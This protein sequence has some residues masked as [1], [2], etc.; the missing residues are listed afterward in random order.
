MQ[1]LKIDHKLYV[2]SLMRVKLD[3]LDGIGGAHDTEEPGNE[4]QTGVLP[5]TTT[6]SGESSARFH[7]GAEEKRE[8]SLSE[9]MESLVFSVSDLPRMLESFVNKS[10]VRGE[11]YYRV[12]R[13]HTVTISIP[14]AR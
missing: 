12:Q 9:L 1:I 13:E 2:V 3:K 11:S 14:S 8:K 7:L 6:A 5:T 4:E 10:R